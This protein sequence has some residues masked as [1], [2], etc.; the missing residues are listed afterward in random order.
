MHVMHAH[1]QTC[2][3]GVFNF[4]SSLPL[5]LWGAGWAVNPQST[6]RGRAHWPINKHDGRVVHA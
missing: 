6:S 2:V 5:L 1:L 4:I 3:L